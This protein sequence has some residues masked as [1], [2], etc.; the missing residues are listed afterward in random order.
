MK[1]FDGNWKAFAARTLVFGVVVFGAVRLAVARPGVAGGPARSSVTVAGTLTNVT[2][3]AMVQ[4]RFYNAQTGG[5]PLCESSVSVPSGPF[6]VEVPLEGAGTSG[7]RCLTMFDGADVFVEVA[8]NGMT[9]RD[10]SAVNPVPYAHFASVAGTANVATQ[11]GTPDCPVGYVRDV[12][13]SSFILCRHRVVIGRD[14]LEDEVVRVGTGLTAF[15]IDR[16]EATAY[17]LVDGGLNGRFGG[18]TDFGALPR[19]GQWATPTQQTSPTRAY[20]VA[21]TLPARWI[22]WFQAQEACR[23]SGKRLPTGEE[24]QAAAQGTPDPATPELGRG[25]EGRCLTNV[26]SS[27]PSGGR[28]PGIG[29]IGCQSVWGAQ[30][31]IGNVGEWT[32]EWNATALR[33]AGTTYVGNPWNFGASDHTWNVNLRTCASGEEDS[34]R[35]LPA[36]SIRGGGYGDSEGAGVH[37]LNLNFSPS[38]FHQEIGFRCVIP[39]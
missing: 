16:Y 26:G 38:D 21:G 10:R 6:S 20:S 14:S 29:L 11:Y 39:R 35:G 27:R 9:I 36:G 25:V 15:W 1:V 13:V 33:C 12:T 19:S 28:A 4:F 24:W 23:A 37:A 3:T 31:M 30:D 5:T 22:T 32:D 8:V 34:R 18:A 2:G 7:P 17:E